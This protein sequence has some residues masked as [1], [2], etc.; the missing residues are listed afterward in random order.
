M[1]VTTI[2]P[3]MSKPALDTDEFI[4]LEDATCHL[5]L[6]Q[7]DQFAFLPAV[8][9]LTNRRVHLSPNYGSS[10]PVFMRLDSIQSTEVTAFDGTPGLKLIGST[11]LA[12]FIPDGTRCVPL[13]NIVQKLSAA[14]KDDQVDCDSIALSLQ[15]RVIQSGSLDAF[16]ASTVG[17]EDHF[18]GSPVDPT[19][20]EALLSTESFPIRLLNIVVDLMEV[21][22]LFAI[23]F[24]FTI[25]CLFSILFYFVPFGVSLCGIIFLLMVRH[26]FAMIFSKKPRRR[27]AKSASE[28][29]PGSMK[30]YDLFVE[31]FRKR[32]LWRN[33]RRTLETVMFL[34]S[35]AVMFGLYDPAFVLFLALVGLAFVE[36]WNPFGFGSI[37]EIFSNLFSF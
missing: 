5:T 4:I 17:D 15:R 14:A 12:F 13:N 24:L 28:F 36:R 19:E 3:A 6:I 2:D 25:L 23:Q 9:Y 7:Q 26:G 35:T 34:L 29:L 21:G 20:A 30:S 32:F 8:L 11:V 10:D 18:D 37:S 16:Y 1:T 27:I 22:D 33:P 31:S